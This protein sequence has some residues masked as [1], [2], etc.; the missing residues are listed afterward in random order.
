MYVYDL[1]VP[2]RQREKE[3]REGAKRERNRECERERVPMM[4]KRTELQTV[5]SCFIGTNNRT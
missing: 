4:Q 1:C 5:R 2:K 3:R